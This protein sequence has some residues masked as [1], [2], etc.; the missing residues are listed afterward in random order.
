MGVALRKWYLDC[1]TTAGDAAILYAGRVALGPVTVP[2]FELMAAQASCPVSRLRRVSGRARV[3]FH[4]HACALDAARL[5]VTG[6]WTSRH[7]SITVA[8]LDDARGR[9]VWRCRQPGG[10][11]TLHLPD[12]SVMTGLGYAEELDMTV[13]PWAMPFE[14]LRWGRFVSEHR[15]V[16]WIDWRGGLDRRWVFA[17]GAAVDASVVERERVVWPDATLEIAPGRVWRH[18]AVG[19]TVAGALARCLP[20]RVSH[21]VETKWLSPASLGD[22]AGATDSGWVIH[23]VVRW[24]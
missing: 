12:G 3:S 16:V 10:T 15:S 4:E 18:G 1:V 11:A 13:A 2:Y 17:D 19:R 9:I 14:E 6:H 21:A 22:T 7:A 5:G 23:E 8:L 20:R 24:G